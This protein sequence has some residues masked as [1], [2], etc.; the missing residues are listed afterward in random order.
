[1]SDRSLRR[2]KSGARPAE[3]DVTHTYFFKNI[4]GENCPNIKSPRRV[5]RGQHQTGLP[6][7]LTGPREIGYIAGVIGEDS[8]IVGL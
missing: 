2:S 4:N 8:E 7:G 5:R 3:E 1:M 6:L